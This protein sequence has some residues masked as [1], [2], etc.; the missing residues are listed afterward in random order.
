[1]LSKKEVTLKKINRIG[2]IL[3]DDL[4]LHKV[5]TKL[6]N[7]SIPEETKIV[8]KLELKAEPE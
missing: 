3:L 1:M 7:P 4:K 8:R 5:H 2:A 6:I